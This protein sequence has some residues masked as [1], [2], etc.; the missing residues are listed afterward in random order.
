MEG[1]FYEKYNNKIKLHNCKIH[2]IKLLSE[3][4]KSSENV[5]I[6]AG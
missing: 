1:K 6:E 2:I 4:V 5:L 3:I